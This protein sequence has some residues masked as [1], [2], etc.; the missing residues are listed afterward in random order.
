M[1]EAKDK[2]KEPEGDHHLDIGQH[3]QLH[4]LQHL[5]DQRGEQPGQHHQPEVGVGEVSC[6]TSMY[7]RMPI[8]ISWAPQGGIAL[9]ESKIV[10][11]IVT[12][13]CLHEHKDKAPEDQHHEGQPGHEQQLEEGDH[14]QHHQHLGGGGEISC[15]ISKHVRMPGSIIQASQGG[16]CLRTTINI[17]LTNYHEFEET[18]RKERKGQEEKDTKEDAT[19]VPGGT[20]EDNKRNLEFLKYCEES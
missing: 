10:E 4:H 7:T 17:P 1:E 19:W 15:A 6:V 2:Q 8:S 3:H 18:E 12:P 11:K 20:E 16:T 13:V 5:D 14:H 9:K